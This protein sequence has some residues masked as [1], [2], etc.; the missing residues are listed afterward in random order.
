MWS[1]D[2][3]ADTRGRCRW[4]L[5]TTHGLIVA[6]SGQEFVGRTNAIRAAHMFRTGTQL[7]DFEVLVDHAKGYRWDAIAADGRIVATSGR[8]FADQHEAARSAAIVA[9]N[10]SAATEPNR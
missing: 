10:A 6:G 7:Y 5:V 3:C 8:H 9:L 4:Q 1:Y 2:V